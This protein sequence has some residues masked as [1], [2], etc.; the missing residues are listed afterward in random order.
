MA[1]L[2]F[3]LLAVVP[4]AAPFP[5]MADMPGVDMHLLSKRSPQTTD[6]TDPSSEAKCPN[7]PNHPGAAPFNPKFGYTNARNGL[8]GNGSG[9]FEVPIDGDTAHNFEAPGPLDIRGPC[10]GLN[11]AANHHVCLLSSCEQAR[12]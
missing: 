9:G 7:N 5:W 1:P 2:I 3:I 4:F 6:T 12:N 11:T 10:P 8:P